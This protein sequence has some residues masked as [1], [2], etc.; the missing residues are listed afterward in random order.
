MMLN[1]EWM[2]LRSV[3]RVTF[4][5]PEGSIT[6]RRSG[7][8]GPKSRILDVPWLLCSVPAKKKGSITRIV[9]W[10]LRMFE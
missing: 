1:F 7:S 8:P 3:Q 9:Q 10:P 2:R 4:D 6:G 5:S